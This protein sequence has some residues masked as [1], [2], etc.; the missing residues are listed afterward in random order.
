MK[1]LKNNVYLNPNLIV[2]LLTWAPL[3]LFV[4]VS[5]M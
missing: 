1:K 3:C 5:H 4:D 2:L